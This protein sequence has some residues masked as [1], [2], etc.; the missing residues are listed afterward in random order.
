M[1]ETPSS[2]VQVQILPP[3]RALFQE[4]RPGPPGDVSE[5]HPTRTCQRPGASDSPGRLAPSRAM[6]VYS[7]TSGK[8]DPVADEETRTECSTHSGEGCD[9]THAS[10]QEIHVETEQK[11]ETD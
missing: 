4:A 8:E 10:V 1:K 6:S 3:V 11:P 7:P 2:F 5:G 9:G